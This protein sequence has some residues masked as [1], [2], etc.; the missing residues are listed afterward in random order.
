[1]TVNLSP[2]ANPGAQFFDDNG[3]PLTGGKVYTYAAG[4]TTP[5][6]TYTTSTGAV[7]SR[8]TTPSCSAS[9]ISSS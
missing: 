9:S 4:T 8:S 5:L 2:F 3:D 1:M 6:A 7:N